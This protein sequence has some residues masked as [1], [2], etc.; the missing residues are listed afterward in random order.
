MLGDV[1][2][3]VIG[4][5]FDATWSSLKA[6]YHEGLEETELKQECIKAQQSISRASKNYHQKYLDIDCEIKLFGNLMPKGIPLESIYT[7]V[8]FLSNSDLKYF[9]GLDNLEKLYRKTGSRNFRIGQNERQD[10]LTVANTEQYLMVLGGPGIGKSTFLRK[11]GLEALTN[12]LAYDLMPVFIELKYLKGEDKSLLQAIAKKLEISGFPY[13]ERLLESM[14]SEGKMLILL[15]GLDEVPSKQKKSAIREIE[16]FCN[17]HSQNRFIISC[18]T[19]AYKGGFKQFYNVTMAEFDDKQIQPFIQRWFNS[20]LDVQSD[21]AEKVW[22]A[23]KQPENASV[24][25]LA[26]TPLLLA[27]LC[28][29]YEHSQSALLHK[30]TGLDA[31]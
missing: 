17:Q 4:P 22:E 16:S 19:A 14:L 28:L 15:D 27:F 29:K 2:N 20:E 6:Q 5:I 3:G 21:T 8:K 24:K 23:L 31:V 30:Q 13:S 26:R 9:E 18:R 11:L 1:I 7:A 12:R 10:G 25:E